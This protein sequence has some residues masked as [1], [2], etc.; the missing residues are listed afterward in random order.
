MMS[1]KAML[2]IFANRASP[3]SY[4]PVGQPTNVVERIL[5]LPVGAGSLGVAR[6]NEAPRENSCRFE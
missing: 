5:G 6:A 2:R 3:S 1:E 4:E